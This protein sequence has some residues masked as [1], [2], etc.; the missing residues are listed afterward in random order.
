MATL[1]GMDLGYGSQVKVVTTNFL[2]AAYGTNGTAQAYANLLHLYNA[3]VGPNSAALCDY[4]IPSTGAA[5]DSPTSGTSPVV[6]DC[7]ASTGT[8]GL[9]HLIGP[10]RSHLSQVSGDGI[11]ATVNDTAA[12]LGLSANGKVLAVLA[13]FASPFQT[14]TDFSGLTVLESLAGTST[15]TDLLNAELQIDALSS[16]VPYVDITS[17]LTD[18]H[19]A[20]G[21]T[22]SL[23]LGEAALTTSF[24]MGGNA[25]GTTATVLGDITAPGTDTTGIISVTALVRTAQ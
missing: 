24:V 23:N 6:A 20:L 17:L 10:S 9:V 7:D 21:G 4:I 8:N 19:T 18:L 3:T 2:V 13:A 11:V 14:G 25:A 1:A 12:N 22:P 5:A 16:S 15:H